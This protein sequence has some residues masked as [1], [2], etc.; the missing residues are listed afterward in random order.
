MIALLTMT[1]EELD[2]WTNVI[3]AVAAVVLLGLALAFA[4]DEISRR[5]GR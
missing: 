4:V 3:I 1:A 5:R 2:L